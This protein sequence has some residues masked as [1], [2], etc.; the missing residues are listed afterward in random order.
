MLDYLRARGIRLVPEYETQD[1]RHAFWSEYRSPRAMDEFE[2]FHRAYRAMLDAAP[3]PGAK[4]EEG[5]G[6][7]AD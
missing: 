6:S 3:G 2:A 1:M 7:S 4:E 5:N